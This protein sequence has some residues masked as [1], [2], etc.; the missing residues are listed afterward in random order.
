C[1]AFSCWWCVI[2]RV[3][4]SVPTRRSSD[5]ES[6]ARGVFEMARTAVRM[7]CDFTI[8]VNGDRGTLVFE[9]A[10]SPIAVDLD[11]EVTRHAHGGARHLENPTGARLEIGGASCRDGETDS[12]NDAPPARERTT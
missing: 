12:L 2:Q 8:E 4:L 11:R 3:R 10:R 1:C 6:G 9:S 5:L 7:P